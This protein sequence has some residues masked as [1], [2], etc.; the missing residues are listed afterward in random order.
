MRQFCVLKKVKRNMRVQ[1]FLSLAV[2]IFFSAF[3][4]CKTEEKQ[5]Q[6]KPNILLIISD[7]QGFADLSCAELTDDVNTPNIDKL[8][9]NG[10]RFTQ[11]YVT[12]PICSPSRASII[13]GCYQERWGTFWYGGK[14]IHNEKYR[15]IAE[16]L[17]E[18]EYSTGYVGKV[19][20]GADDSDTANRNFPLNHGFDSYIGFTS[21]RKHYINHTD[22]LEKS[23][24][25]VKKEHKKRGQSLRQQALWNNFEKLDTIAFSTELFGK[26]ACEF[27]DKNQD[28]P[29]FLQL[30]FNAV[31]NFTHQLP[32]EYLSEKGLSGGEDWDPS[33][34]EYYDWYQKSRYPNNP[35]GRELY[36]GQL[37]YLDKEIG[38][39]LDHLA[40]L[41]LDK[42][43]IVIYISDNGG[44][45]PI[46]ANNSP[47]R[48]SKYLLYEG[49]I[50]VPMIISYPEKYSKGEVISTV[51]SSM[52]I[53]PTICEAVG[54]ETPE[55][56]D[57]LELN[58]L[59]SDGESVNYHDTLFWDTGSETAVRAGKWKY[60][61]ANND[62]DAKFEMVELE[63]GAFLYDMEKD[64]GETTNLAEQYP[65]IF[66]KLK[67]AHLRWR[68]SL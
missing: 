13:T 52:D 12:A 8:A 43:T 5:S 50:R 62:E 16:I 39:V 58:S 35:E 33:K 37:Y 47:L 15:T 27:L 56:V 23:F 66:N 64:P 55:Y 31:H 4:S 30:A 44:S 36:L 19:H 6:E 46:Y 25:T 17:K 20:Y 59:L 48:G 24:R 49:G 40:E 32:Q 10:V 68:N 7:D 51:V 65:E 11:A 54:I 60:H 28:K 18:Q 2:L 61:M 53:F 45:T 67:S 42:N 22:S 14:G 29:F 34:E 38:R 1:V 57:G 26:K 63:L 41:N 21:A 3:Q 9:Q